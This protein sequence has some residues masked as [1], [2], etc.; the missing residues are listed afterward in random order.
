[1]PVFRALPD[2]L[3]SQV[4]KFLQAVEEN[5]KPADFKKQTSTS[6]VTRATGGLAS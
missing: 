5:S 1:M 4:S 2:L 3:H 6:K